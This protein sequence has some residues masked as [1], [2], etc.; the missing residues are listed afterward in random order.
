MLLPGTIRLPVK[1]ALLT[2]T[3]VLLAIPAFAAEVRDERRLFSDGSPQEV[4]TYDGSILPETLLLKEL[5]WEA[6]T[7]RSVQTFKDGV[8]HGSTQTWYQNGNRES[9][10]N[11][12]NG[13]RHGMVIHWPDPYE[14]PKRK[15]QLKPKLQAEWVDGKQHGTWNEWEGWGE[16][17]WL[18]VEKTYVAGQLDGFETIWRSKDRM[19]RKL[20]WK[21]GIRH[22]RQL[23]WDGSGQ[24][25]WQYNFT[26]G[27]PDGPQRKYDRDDIVQ[28]LFF[29]AGLLHGE[30]TWES[31][32]EDLGTSW[33]NGLRTDERRD[34]AGTLRATRRYEFV[35]KE[36][37]VDYD[38]NLQFH[39]ED[40]L[41][42]TTTYYE[43]GRRKTVKVEG[44]PKR[45]LTFFPDGRLQRIGGEGSYNGPVLEWYPDGTLFREELWE[46]HKKMG[47][48]RIRDPLGRVVQ[49]QEWDF[50]LKSQTVTIWHD[51]NTKASEGQIQIASGSPSGSKDGSWTYWRTDGSVL[52][53]E[54]YGPGPYSGNR[55]FIE[56]MV[57]YDEEERPLFDGSER[58]L[59]LYDYDSDEPDVVRRKRTIKLLDRSRHGLEYWNGQTLELERKPVK[60]P[61]ELSE[62]APVVDGLCGGRGLVR[63]DEN[64]R[65]DGTAKRTDRY[66]RGGH[67]HGL[68]EGWY[69]DGTRAY[70]FDYHRGELRQ[71]KEW[72]SDG[73]PRLV[74]MLRG[75]ELA[76]LQLSDKGGTRWDWEEDRR[77]RGPEELLERCRVFEFDQ[78]IPRP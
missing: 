8:Q 45:L 71:A 23:G 5:F 18:R 70:V 28:E 36:Q 78:R 64:F 77:W 12:V 67:R 62:D 34:D 11:W 63:V 61:T 37:A 33:R 51:Q 39:G 73:S 49:V 15:K 57:E 6:G 30:M 41:V 3:L 46:G 52:R 13:K 42:D 69:R 76:T 60:Q 54:Q 9:E 48:W 14:D 16:D 10:E 72:W 21:Q 44:S 38:G 27:L 2:A 29:V 59:F 43:D 53:T 47:T 1:K 22:G 58:E 35:L 32:L 68:Q 40:K 31:W 25:A 50:Y 4:W 17:R 7:K 55:P 74:L 56:N 75:D 24:M 20:S 19:Q 26:D 66:D 65:S